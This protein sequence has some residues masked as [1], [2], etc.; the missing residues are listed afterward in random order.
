MERTGKFF[1]FIIALLGFSH[2]I[3]GCGIGGAGDN[4]KADGGTTYQIA[5]HQNPDGSP[6]LP[7]ETAAWASEESLSG[8]LSN[9]PFR[10][11]QV[12]SKTDGE[13]AAGIWPGPESPPVQ[14][15][16]PV[17]KAKKLKLDFPEIGLA[18]SGSNGQISGI[19]KAAIIIAVA[20]DQCADIEDSSERIADG[21]ED[22]DLITESF[23][24]I[25]NDIPLYND[26]RIY[27][28]E[29]GDIF[30]L[31]FDSDADG[32]PDTN[33]FSM[34][35][36]THVSL[37]FID[38]N[39]A[40]PSGIAIPQN[41]P[42]DNPDTKAGLE[43][44]A[45]PDCLNQPEILEH[46]LKQ[47]ITAGLDALKAGW[48][49]G[50]KSYFED[51]EDL[52]G[53]SSSGDADA[54]RFFY[55]LT[56]VAVLWLDYYSDEMPDNFPNPLVDILDN[57][58]SAA[59]DAKGPDPDAMLFAGAL[60][61]NP[62]AAAD[63]LCFLSNVAVAELEGALGNLDAVSEAFNKQWMEPNNHHIVESDYSDVLFLKATFKAILAYIFSQN[64]CD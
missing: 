52:A 57:F 42:T 32:N 10:G 41:S 56:R 37:G 25:F 11:F 8:S 18:A 46:V 7:A 49:H 62:D 1:F 13:T 61:A 47:L 40:D 60:P 12:R 4:E 54:A 33:V 53:N 55:A 27:L 59:E 16:P 36:N 38:V 58:G 39:A 51:A 20:D 48:V 21:D 50:A 44:G 45:L 26:I 23:S 15:L 28:F 17:W 3:I 2:L 14:P 29:K 64:A 19:T 24:F 34:I 22:G 63:L 9:K 6:M 43:D 35:S 31:Y 5:N 30:P